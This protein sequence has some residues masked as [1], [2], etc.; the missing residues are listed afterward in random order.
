MISNCGVQQPR[1]LGA[2]SLA[3]PAKTSFQIAGGCLPNKKQLHETASGGELGILRRR[4]RPC[5]ICLTAFAFELFRSRY[6]L[7]QVAE[8]P[9][10]GQLG[11]SADPLQTG[12]VLRSELRWVLGSRA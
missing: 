6:Q 3:E 11:L 1:P 10:L 8:R 7:V 5:N 2:S 4:A 9:F 12:L